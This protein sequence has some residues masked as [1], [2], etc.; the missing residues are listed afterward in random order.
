MSGTLHTASFAASQGKEVFVLPNNIYYENAL[1]GLK[2]LEDGGNV[3]LSAES[4]IDSVARSLMYKRMDMGC[5]VEL[6]YQDQIKDEFGGE[7]DIDALRELSKIKPEALT[8]DNWKALIKDSLTLKPMCA[9]ELCVLTMLPF[10]KVSKLLT[11]LELNG[12]V[13]Q[14]KGKYSLTF[15]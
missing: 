5:P 1:G 3:L 8:D 14:E 9:D 10:Y 6:Y 12:T 11:E 13:C 7:P 2:L 4:V 15:V